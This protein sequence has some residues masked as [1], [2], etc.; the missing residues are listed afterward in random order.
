MMSCQNLLFLIRVIF[1]FSSLSLSLDRSFALLRSLSPP[2]KK[3]RLI[4]SRSLSAKQIEMRARG[5]PK[6]KK[7]MFLKQNKKK[8]TYDTHKNSPGLPIST[9]A[10]IYL[11][12]KKY[13][14]KQNCRMVS[15][16]NWVPEKKKKKLLKIRN[17]KFEIVLPRNIMKIHHSTE[18][19]HYIT[20]RL[21]RPRKVNFRHQQK[22]KK[23]F[24][25]I[26]SEKKNVY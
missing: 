26:V 25:N 1:F 10:K 24:L 23:Y 7:K 21:P 6:P 4:P 18:P 19:R 12:K 13:Q 15:L 5:M 9:S 11:F 16:S 2:T 17:R 8:I 14:M 20:S 3:I 22:R